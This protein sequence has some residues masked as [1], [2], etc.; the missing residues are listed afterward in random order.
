VQVPV[1]ADHDQCTARVADDA[2][3]PVLRTAPESIDATNLQCRGRG[4][5]GGSG[6]DD[7]HV[8]QAHDEPDVFEGVGFDRVLNLSL[9]LRQRAARDLHLGE[10][11]REPQS[12]L[13]GRAD[14]ASCRS[15]DRLMCLLHRRLGQA[16][17]HRC[18]EY[19]P[20]L[21]TAAVGDLG[22]RRR[23][24]V[25]GRHMASD[26]QARAAGA[27]QP[28]RVPAACRFEGEVRRT[29]QAQRLIRVCRVRRAPRRGKDHVGVK[30]I[31]RRERLLVKTPAVAIRFQGGIASHD[32]AADPHFAVGV[33]DEQLLVHDLFHYS[34][35]GR[36]RAVLEQDE[37]LLHVHRQDRTRGGAGAAEH[38]DR[39]ADVRERGPHTALL[40]RNDRR[41]NS[42]I[43][44]GRDRLSGKPGV[45]IDVVGGRA[46]HRV[47]DALSD[48][49]QSFAG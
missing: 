1:V 46:G 9:R 18:Q 38:T 7:L 13:R 44:Q 49:C 32:V 24:Q 12:R 31:R 21:T 20:Q 34:S 25:I 27:A 43:L 35:Q 36:R 42:L 40:D 4:A 26:V 37:H 19:V 17:P 41:E 14:A 28:Q 10:Y 16:G 23:E 22:E 2:L 45:E 47:G 6:R 48:F 29:E 8:A 39:V 3:E 11:L 33:G 15:A 5:H 30:T